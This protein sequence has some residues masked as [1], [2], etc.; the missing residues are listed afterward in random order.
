MKK[1]ILVTGGAGYIGSAMV[2][3][4][5]K[6]NYEVVV[7]DNLST[8]KKSLVHKN[9]IFYECDIT[10]QLLL[11]RSIFYRYKFDAVIHFAGY[12]AVEESMNNPV[13]YSDNLIGLT[14]ILNNM[15]KHKINKIIFSSSAAVYGEPDYNPI[16][17]KHKTTP[18]NYYGFLKLTCEQL[19]NWYSLTTNIVGINLRY[20]N[21]VGDAGLNYLDPK[22]KNVLPIIFD[23]ITGKRKDFN[24]FGNDYNTFDGTCV[25]DYIDINDLIDAHLLS[26]EVNNSHTINLGT[27]TGF[28][29]LELIRAVEGVINKI[30]EFNYVNRRVGDPDEL[31]A[32]N[33]KAL[34]ILNWSP[35]V[36]I[37]KSIKSM[38]DVYTK[39]RGIKNG[40]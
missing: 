12:K 10:K 5:I 3:K 30:I 28:S 40:K 11:L 13:K 2:D 39:E 34:E 21:V 15:V 14:N 7:L 24:I 32:S 1:T 23:F 25:R 37:K 16:D 22:P 31:V 20:F 18:I 33:S 29:V 8:G 27:S 17:E 19:I 6:N 26:L 38:Y 36:D 4:L 9:A 35:K